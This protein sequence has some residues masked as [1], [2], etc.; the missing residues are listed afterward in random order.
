M[1]SLPR[2]YHTRRMTIHDPLCD[3]KPKRR[4]KPFRKSINV[5]VNELELK[6]S[7]ST[8]LARLRS[9]Q[10]FFS[11]SVVLPTRSEHCFR[12]TA[13]VLACSV[14]SST[15]LEYFAKERAELY[16]CYTSYVVGQ[17]P[18][19]TR[20]AS[21]FDLLCIALFVTSLVTFIC[22]FLPFSIVNY[23]H[24]VDRQRYVALAIMRRRIQRVE[25]FRGSNDHIDEDD[26]LILGGFEE[27]PS[28]TT[29]NRDAHDDVTYWE[30]VK[31]ELYTRIFSI[32]PCEIYCNWITG[33]RSLSLLL[34]FLSAIRVSVQCLLIRGPIYL[35]CW[36]FVASTVG[37]LLAPFHAIVWVVPLIFGSRH[38]YA[39]LC[40]VGS[41][42]SIKIAGLVIGKRLALVHEKSLLRQFFRNHDLWRKVNIKEKTL[43]YLLGFDGF[44]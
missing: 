31:E 30:A 14:I 4:C 9:I 8:R 41:I 43:M 10:R 13:F 44:F 3:D 18:C 28:S 34:A 23:L 29:S 7:N 12:L 16:W 1:S 36:I 2:G 33:R 22:S 40:T 26:C 42:V 39:G 17:T 27:R 15:I 19:D 32:V 37:A 35:H 24:G 25:K 6:T 21:K 20:D 5:E 11:G 38:R